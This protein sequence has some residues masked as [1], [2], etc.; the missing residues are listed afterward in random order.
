VTRLALGV[1]LFA[2]SAL[3][4]GPDLHTVLKGVENRYNH[5]RTLQVLFSQT[6][7]MPQHGT[8]TES[9]ELFLRKPGR[10]RWQY[11]DPAG[12]L[13]VSDGKY[14][15][16]Y[17]PSQNRVERS[18]VKESDDMRAP[19]AFLLGRLDFEQEFSTFLMKPEGENTWITAQ[20]KSDRLPFTQVKFLVTPSY[21]IREL[22]ITG[23]D[24]SVMSF[25]FSD[26]KMNPKLSDNM[27]QF[28]APAG[29]EV[30]ESEG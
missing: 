14:I 13:F 9:G 19:L 16:L 11:T 28:K 12:K 3:A 25:K 4:A 2:V 7:E 10:M 17:T 29:A 26:E 18:K 6:Y 5:A 22:V 27:F 23:Q 21:E 20:A 1:C 15:Y 24:N 8:R 30:V